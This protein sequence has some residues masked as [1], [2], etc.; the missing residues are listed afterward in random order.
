[1][2]SIPRSLYIYY[3]FINTC[4]V[5]PTSSSSV[6]ATV[7]LRDGFF[8]SAC[9]VLANLQSMQ[10]KI[11]P[12]GEM[13]WIEILYSFSLTACH[14]VDTLVRT[15]SFAFLHSYV[16]VCKPVCIHCSRR[17]CQLIRCSIQPSVTRAHRRCR[18]LYEPTG[19]GLSYRFVFA[20]SA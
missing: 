3:I 18:S 2:L 16:R 13:L 20:W 10:L 4:D 11:R 6:H 12:R 7:L 8:L 1:M 15:D 9:L 5:T 14:R 19:N 17:P